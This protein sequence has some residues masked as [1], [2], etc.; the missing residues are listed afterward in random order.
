M[1]ATLLTPV[2]VVPA[3]VVVVALFAVL[4]RERASARDARIALLSGGALGVWALA[5]T[6]LAYRGFFQPQD[7]GSVPPVAIGLVLALSVLSAILATSVSLRRLLSR[8]ASLI[9]L[10][11]WRLEGIVFL[12]LMVRGQMPA[13]WALP[14]GIGDV[15]VAATAPWIARNL[16]SPRGRRRAIVW[17]LLGMADLVVAVAL[18]IMTNPGSLQVFATV[19]TSEPITR[20]PLALVPAFLV[21]L[22]LTLHVVSLCQLLGKPWTR[23]L[24]EYGQGGA[25]R[26]GGHD[27][28]VVVDGLVTAWRSKS[29]PRKPEPGGTARALDSR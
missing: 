26:D 13:L 21:P 25:V 20:F 18:G 5:S 11:L 6:V 15:L 2:V 1:S 16:D 3:A 17:N 28:P 9:R 29:G 14:A 4:W 7:A 8:Q 24:A 27:R 22:A 12:A 19:P 23:P 10:H